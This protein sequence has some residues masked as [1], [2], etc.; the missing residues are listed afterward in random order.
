[1]IS[2]KIISKVHEEVVYSNSK[3]IYNAFAIT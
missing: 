1:M 2:D 3:N